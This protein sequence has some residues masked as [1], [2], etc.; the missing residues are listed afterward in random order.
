MSD[1][2]PP[3]IH[4]WQMVESRGRDVL[5]RY[6]FEEVRTPIVEYAPVFERSI[7]D[8]TDVVQKEMYTFD[9]RGGR[10]LALRPEGTAG[11]MRYVAGAGP[12]AENARIYYIGPMFRC[13]RPQAGRRRQFHQLGVEIIG[14]AG[15]ALDAECIALQHHLLTEWGLSR[16]EI[17]VNTRGGFE[18][19]RAVAEGLRDALR[20]KLGELCEDCRRRFEVNVLRV[21]DCKQEACRGMVAELPPVTAFMKPESRQYLDE[22]L[23]ILALLEIKVRV[24]PRLVRGLDYYVDTVWE[25]THGALGAQDALSGGGRYRID[26]GDQVI[27]G[28]GFAAGLERIV[29]ALRG[30]NVKAEDFAK[31]PRVW[32]VSLGEKAL[33][34][35]LVLA[36]ALRRRG[37]R[38]EMDLR[39]RS[40]KAQ[41]RAANRAG[42]AAV[43]IRGDH[44]MEKGTFLL[45]DMAGGAQE[46][47]A[48][49]D[50]MERLAPVHKV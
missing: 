10:R 21:L 15:A 43:V 29:A 37:V 32:I 41:M 11:M 23:R 1:L 47:L 45:K 3:E 2:A 14:P 39:G 26:V 38:C 6:G 27:E 8:T 28:V 4:L 31:K 9:D 5:E 12:E 35:N 46:E 34:E 33:E 19:R 22:V 13:E 42:A 24:E 7:G 18:D 44:E 49:P 16:C 30:E 25:I 20:P 48:M 50:L 36:M 40:M 17:V